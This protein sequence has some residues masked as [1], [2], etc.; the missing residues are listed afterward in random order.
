MKGPVVSVI[1]PTHNRAHYLGQTIQS[2]LEQTRSDFEILV[3]DNGSTDNTKEVVNSFGDQRI[4]Y[5]YQENSGSPVSPRNRGIRNAIGKYI[6]FLDSDDLWLPEKIEKQVAFLENN[7]SVPIV[8]SDSYIINERGDIVNKCSALSKPYGGNIF[9]RLL[10]KNFMP[11]LTVVLK[12]DVALNYGCLDEQYKISHD[13]DLYLKISN[14]YKVGYLDEPLAKVRFH[15]DSM[16]AD[17]S[18]M[19][20][21]TIDVV[22]KWRYNNA[23]RIPDLYFRKI[24]SYYSCME[25]FDLLNSN[26]LAQARQGFKKAFQY[27]PFNTGYGLLYSLSLVN[28]SLMKNVYNR[29]NKWRIRF[30]RR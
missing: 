16:I 27:F 21:E 20:R 26:Q 14:D 2:V 11:N 22:K 9:K 19:R 10:Q 7:P 24:L 5:F 28:S 3:I 30:A 17:R 29:L 12:R 15:R 1:I 6:A 8:Y 18:L 23:I 4:R 25:A 13:I